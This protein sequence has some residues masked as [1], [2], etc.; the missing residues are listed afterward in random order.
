MPDLF[1]VKRRIEEGYYDRPEV[2]EETVERMLRDLSGGRDGDVCDGSAEPRR[3]HERDA[4]GG[5][6]DPAA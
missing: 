5:P 2:I 1:A 6:G 4:D 3:G